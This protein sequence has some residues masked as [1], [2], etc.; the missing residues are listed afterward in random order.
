MNIMNLTPHP[1]TFISN[2]N[3]VTV[4]PSGII[5]RVSA[6][7]EIIDEINGI[8]VTTTVFGEV[9]D[10]P[11]KENDTI[12]IVSSLVAQRVPERED[13]FIPNE[14]IRDEEGKIIGC[15]SLGRI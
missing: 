1:V 7:T 15:K 10:L 9:T 3:S 6:S 14:P 13:V 4:N 12:Y 11:T 2:G 5:A 8:P